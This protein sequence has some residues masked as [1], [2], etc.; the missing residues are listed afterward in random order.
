MS[1]H[2]A[3]SQLATRLQ[4]HDRSHRLTKHR[5][6]NADDSRFGDHRMLMQDVFD[7]ARTDLLAAALNDVVLAA[8]PIQEPFFVGAEQI[9]RVYGFKL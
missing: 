5:I 3:D 2:V 6:I 9:A 8:D 7:F 4:S 1:L